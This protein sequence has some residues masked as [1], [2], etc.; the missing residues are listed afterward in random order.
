L[1]TFADSEC[2]IKCNRLKPTCEACQ[3]FNCACI[4][5]G[6]YV[7]FHGELLFA[8]AVANRLLK[9]LRR[10]N[11]VPRQTCWKHCSSG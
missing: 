8:K 11:E 2:K 6:S 3:A 4:Y 1:S 5:G 7:V 9:M 10:R